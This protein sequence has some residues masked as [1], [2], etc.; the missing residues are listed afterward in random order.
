MKTQLCARGMLP[1][2]HAIRSPITYRQHASAGDRS[3]PLG[4]E[5]GWGNLHLRFVTRGSAGSWLMVQVSGLTAHGQWG[6]TWPRGPG[7]RPLVDVAL[8]KVKASQRV[9]QQW[10]VDQGA[11]Y[12]CN[13]AVFSL[14]YMLTD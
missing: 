7:A 2:D 14:G 12:S 10:L 1:K 4:A 8:D 9:L 11:K 13:M 5:F 3:F 6:S